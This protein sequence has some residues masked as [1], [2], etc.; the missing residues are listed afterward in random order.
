MVT[1]CGFF[2][3]PLK[4]LKGHFSGPFLLMRNPYR[5]LAPL[6]LTVAL[7]VSGCQA[8]ANRPLKGEDA[9]APPIDAPA[10]SLSTHA[11]AESFYEVLVAEM[12]GQQGDFASSYELLMRA[13]TTREQDDLFQRAGQAALHM[14]DGERA[15]R[16]AKVWQDTLPQSR[17]ANKVALQLLIAMNRIPQTQWHLKQELRL[18]PDEEMAENL[19]AIP[20]IYQR[21]PN[22][23]IAFTVV[24]AALQAQLQP[25]SPWRGDALAVLGRLRLHAGDVA[26]AFDYLQ[27]AHAAN[28]Q[29]GGM[30]LFA[31]ELFNAGE[32]RAEPLLRAYADEPAAAP[33]FLLAYA[34]WQIGRGQEAQ[35]LQTLVRLTDKKPDLPEAWLAKAALQAGQRDYAGAR[36]SLDVLGGLLDNLSNAQ[37]RQ[38]G[39]DEAAVLRAQMA[40]LEGE[41][42]QADRWIAQIEDAE[43]A[44]RAQVQRARILAEAGRLAHARHILQSV[45][46]ENAQQQR[47]KVLA[48]VQL[49]RDAQQFEQAYVL[50]GN[51]LKSHP[52]DGDLAYEH[53]LLAE[54]AGHI[55]EMEK[56]LRALLAR[57]PDHVHA[58][59]ALGYSL[60]DRGVR[61][62]EARTLIAKALE[63]EPES[64]H[65]IDSMGWLEYR[66][67]RLPQAL[68]LLQKAYR[69]EADPEI[70]AHLGE[71]L[72]KL[73]QHDEAR[74]VWRQGLAR[75]AKNT[76]L[77][78][79]IERLD[80][81]ASALLPTVPHNKVAP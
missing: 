16:A 30:G 77:R 72:W 58:L 12:L 41:Y 68:E 46:A 35:A 11:M 42:A 79:T 69:I 40:D 74:R 29:S 51:L 39:L 32:A 26:A 66:L 10:Q 75:D 5:S 4:G 37:A 73:E 65:I 76:V 49:L 25:D 53:A 34:R 20:L 48:E 38:R 47:L 67:G 3:W 55:K 24:Q 62:S 19:Y 14:G 43:T 64:A 23:E 21:T 18:T 31:L 59:N 22:K 17:E 57:Q 28:A 8:A 44:M 7:L 60:A 1:P 50:L 9:A 78:A 15:L 54:R 2:L 52:K 6:G 56:S 36:T 13:A 45:P 81:P 80:G 71:V 70:A 63:L 27:Q 61:L 33:P